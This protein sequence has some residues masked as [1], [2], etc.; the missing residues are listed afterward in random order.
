MAGLGKELGHLLKH[1]AIY[2]L[3]NV[4]GKAIGFFLIPLYTHYIP[5]A[6]YGILELLDLSVNV[7]GMFVG[8]GL[9][10]AVAR[11]YYKYELEDE[12][13]KVVSTALFTMIALA[14]VLLLV[15][16]PFAETIARL[17]LGQ[18][19]LSQYVQISLATFAL[20]AILEIPLTYIRAQERSVLFSVFALSRLAC[21][22]ALNIYFIV[23]VE[24]G[25]LG[26]LYSG[27]ITSALFSTVLTI[28]CFKD[29]GVQFERQLCWAMVSFGAPLILNSFG[30]FIINFGDRFLLKASA[31]LETVGVY[32]LGYKLGMGLVSFL[33]GQPFFM[34]WSIRRYSLVKEEGGLD[35]YGQIFLLYTLLMLV[36]CLFLTAFS[37]ELIHFLAPVEYREAYAVLPLIAFGYFFR[38]VSDFFRGAFMIADKTHLS[39]G[40]IV[41]VTA[42]CIVN[43]LFF[44]PKFQAMGAAIAT[45]STFFFMAVVHGY[46]AQKIMPV[47]YR[48]NR[49]VPLVI[50]FVFLGG[51]CFSLNTE[52]V[53]LSTFFLKLTIVTFGGIFSFWIV[54]NKNERVYIFSF[55]RSIYQRK[56]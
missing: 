44:I 42:Y 23:F 18:S 41:V 40:I 37:Y 6:D 45:V 22:L 13:N 51:C 34:I 33:I 25:I 4:L 46:F 12:R 21:S 14:T 1:S 47:N 9:V 31:S 26:I 54:F 35:K 24:L 29:V 55:V 20:N 3:T 38:E 5:P 30:M 39:G 53:S 32:S 48:W 50:F 27:L 17:V 43:Y 7:V 52:L 56:I 11:F 15:S 16:W 8:M 10:S 19:Q 28:S 49:V 2:G 36:L